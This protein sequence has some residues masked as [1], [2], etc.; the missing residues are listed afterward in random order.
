MGPDPGVSG[1]GAFRV[2]GDGGGVEAVQA[3]ARTT[4][5]DPP[6]TREPARS[7]HDWKESQ[8][9]FLG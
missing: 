1:W 3:L 5:S 4:R 7:G 2:R 8:V 6:R 9:I